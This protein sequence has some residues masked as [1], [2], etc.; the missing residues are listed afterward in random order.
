MRF[1][2][3]LFDSRGLCHDQ[4]LFLGSLRQPTPRAR[5]YSGFGGVS[6]A[7]ANGSNPPDPYAC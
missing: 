2:L 3:A 4:S 1:Q 6:E 5:E 7:E